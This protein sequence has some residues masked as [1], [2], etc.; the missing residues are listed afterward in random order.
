MLPPK[1]LKLGSD[2]REL[3][4]PLG[5]LGVESG[6]ICPDGLEL[7]LALLLLLAGPLLKAAGLSGDQ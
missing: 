4:L 3:L 6:E 7:A 1:L 5:M 2:R